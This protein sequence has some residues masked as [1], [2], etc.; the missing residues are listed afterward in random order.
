[1]QLWTNIRIISDV[2]VVII[3]MKMGQSVFYKERGK[4]CMCIS[5]VNEYAYSV[6]N[7]RP[8]SKKNKKQ[9]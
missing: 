7:S 2:Y 9:R 6:E 4:N 8:H 3:V 1:M 5:L